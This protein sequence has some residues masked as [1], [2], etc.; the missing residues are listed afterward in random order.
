M[1]QVQIP[2]RC[3]FRIPAGFCLTAVPVFDL[4]PHRVGPAI[5]GLPH[6]LARFSI[7]LMLP[8]SDKYQAINSLD[9]RSEREG[10][11]AGSSADTSAPT[12]RSELAGGL[13]EVEPAEEPVEVLEMLPPELQHLAEL[14]ETI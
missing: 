11:V 5:C 6:L 12:D 1:A 8:T 3:S 7:R 2:H 4:S 10:E 14:E 13:G 9:H